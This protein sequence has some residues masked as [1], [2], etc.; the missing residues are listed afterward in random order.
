MLRITVEKIENGFYAECYGTK[1]DA[2][3]RCVNFC[4][5]F[6][7]LEAHLHDSIEQFKTAEA[8]REEIAAMQ[9]RISGAQKR[10]RDAQQAGKSVREC[11]A[12]ALDVEP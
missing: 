12:A 2:G 3:Q 4:A 11:V 6:A 8:E 10:Y 9:Q 7:E 1:A 5:T